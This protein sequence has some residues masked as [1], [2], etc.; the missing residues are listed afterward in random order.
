MTEP[1][2]TDFPYRRAEGCPFDPPPQ[3]ASLR[4]ERPI[5]R[6][7][8]PDGQV[9]WLVSRHEDQRAILADPRFGADP[10]QPG[11]PA[12]NEG[13]KDRRR[14]NEPPLIVQD[15][16]QHA[17][18]RRMFVPY[19]TVRRANEMKPRIEQIVDTVLDDMAAG[20]SPTDLVT[21][22]ALP[23]PSLV[24]SDMLGV[25][26]EDSEFFQD[27]SERMIRVGDAPETMVVAGEELAAYMADLIAAK[28]A[29][30]ADD[31]LSVL[32]VN[33]LRTGAISHRQLVQNAMMFLVAGHE[34]TANM[35]SLGF[36][37]LHHNPD[38][39]ALLRDSDDPAVA[40]A[41]ADELLRYLAIVQNGRGR[42]VLEDVEIGG[43]RMRAGEGV[44]LLMDSAN[45]DEEVFP[46]PDRLDI[47]RPKANRHI[48]FGF[49]AH[50]C[51]GQH[52][53]RLELQLAMPALL[54]RF[55]GL[56]PTVAAE[57]ARYKHDMPLYGVYELPVAW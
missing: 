38:Q 4:R 21:A 29:A 48:S 54:R 28:D 47:L 44:V 50:Q 16:P 55:P 36:L 14:V 49:G 2:I 15:D 52:M 18:F 13:I 33:H 3:Y 17:Y 57:D 10:I 30:P 20:G 34:T 51:L 22:F 25:P 39:L 26:P 45:R 40:E 46:D 9:A 35:L 12:Q 32:V 43:V 1:V 27:A 6:V 31:L 56:H 37:A 11:Y 7:E 24:I 5:T 23:L 53:A 42:A 41:S 19:F 8:L